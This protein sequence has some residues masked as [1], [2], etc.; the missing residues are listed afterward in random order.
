MKK[1]A[2]ATSIAI[3]S[4]FSALA[5]GF[6]GM[7][8]VTNAWFAADFTADL[9]T[10]S[11]IVANSSTGVTYG[12]GTWTTVP[13]TGTAVIAA[14]EDAGGG[15]T[16]LSLEAPGEELTFTPSPYASPS[17]METFVSELKADALD[18]DL[19]AL[20]PEVQS[21]FTL[22]DDGEGNV[23]AMAWTVSGWTNFTYA[24]SGL[25]NAWFTL[26][27]DFATVGGVRYVR[28]SVKPAS[29]SFAI[30]TDASGAAWFQSPVNA[31]SV[32]SVS[33]SG[34]ADV[35]SFGG[36]SLEEVVV[37]EVNGVGYPSVSA[38]IAA[39]NAGDTVTLVKT[40]YN[41]LIS[42]TKNVSIDLNS[43]PLNCDSFNIAEG[44]TLTVINTGNKQIKAPAFTGGGSIVAGS[45]GVRLKATSSG[46]N[47][48]SITT[49]DGGFVR[50]DGGSDGGTL[51]VGEINSSGTL[52][53]ADSTLD[54]S[55]TITATE[56]NLNAGNVDGR[57]RLNAASG[58][59]PVQTRVVAD[60]IHAPVYG[61]GIVTSRSGTVRLGADS[62]TQLVGTINSSDVTVTG[63]GITTIYGTNAI[64]GTLTI[65]EGATLVF[66]NPY[67]LGAAVRNYDASSSVIVK[68]ENNYVVSVTD[69]VS[70]TIT[71]APEA[72]SIVTVVEGV[73]SVFGG[74]R[75][76]YTDT[77]RLRDSGTTATTHDM[78]TFLVW[79][80][81]S[82]TAAYTAPL[83][84]T[85][86]GSGSI[87]YGIQT[88]NKAA[89]PYEF[90]YSNSFNDSSYIFSNGVGG[91]W[92]TANEQCLTVCGNWMYNFNGS[93]YM[94]FGA[95]LSGNYIAEVLIYFED[96]TRD[97]RMAIESK[98]MGKWGVGGV[99]YTPVDSAVRISLASGS[100]LDLGGLA[101]TV[102]SVAGSGVVSNGILNVTDAISVPVGQTLVIPY[103]SAYT[104]ASGTGEMIDTIAGTVTL[105]HLA[106]DIDG[107]V[108][109]TVA[110]AIAA[111]ETGTLTVHEDR[112][113]KSLICRDR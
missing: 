31:S 37:A 57:N 7:N 8:L 36:D 14:D 30:L 56:L 12:A 27:T 48:A 74:R 22:F 68:D 105:R 72:G 47:L 86:S 34:T 78:T 39:A 101:Q 79:K 55:G 43:N 80:K 2:I 104:L 51:A 75:A 62:S 52:T 16:M 58:G 88:H 92:L 106:A 4:A 93:N 29:G 83:Y 81:G 60:E 69:K 11:A 73:N 95:S 21:A 63:S 28:Y 15:K 71:C 110:G 108:Y 42:I 18:S 82:T 103:G 98:L 26:Y 109:D 77:T 99:A 20:G 10:G 41:E 32:T 46:S 19:P 33:L 24:A 45:K 97:E 76:F 66:G 64:S 87:A 3:A 13:A 100:V 38:A 91:G 112:N 113:Y 111:Y 1:L 94:R 107:V 6:D 5:A 53:V 50:I 89:G 96:F 102:Q 61:S 67:L 65:G 25:T 54:V 40:A 70:G 17:G 23:S 59:I 49:T 84:D 35:R 9:A 85:S 90:R 44:T